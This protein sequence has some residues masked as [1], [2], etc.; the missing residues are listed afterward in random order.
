M[1]HAPITKHRQR[2]QTLVDSGRFSDEDAVLDAALGL[3]EQREQ[4]REAAVA[5]L[6]SASGEPLLEHQEVFVAVRQR[7]AEVAGLRNP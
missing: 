7:I 4:L 6:E 3:L 1:D 5:G 2:V